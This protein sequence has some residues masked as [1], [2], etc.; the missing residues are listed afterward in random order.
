MENES[1][2]H[3]NAGFRKNDSRIIISTDA[4]VSHKE[5]AGPYR[6]SFSVS[7]SEAR[8]LRDELT[9]IISENKGQD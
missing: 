7:L 4:Y 6:S 8:I 5:Q 3:I 2:I 1:M 9:E